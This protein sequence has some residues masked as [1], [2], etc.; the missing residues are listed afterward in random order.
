MIMIGAT[1]LEFDHRDRKT[2]RRY[3]LAI[4]IY[5]VG[6]KG[7]TA[8]LEKCASVVPTVTRIRTFSQMNWKAKRLS[9]RGEY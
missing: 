8:E 9:D 1:V 7:L 2:V 3:S 5:K 4:R 6:L